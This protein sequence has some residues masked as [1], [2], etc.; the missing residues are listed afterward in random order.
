MRNITIIIVV[1]SNITL[2]LAQDGLILFDYFKL[3]CDGS[4]YVENDDIFNDFT[5]VGAWTKSSSSK[6]K[7][8]G[9][10]MINMDGKR[11][12]YADYIGSEKGNAMQISYLNQA[13]SIT[14]NIKRG[15]SL[16]FT[17]KPLSYSN[18]VYSAFLLDLSNHPNT[19]EE[20]EIFDYHKSGGISRGRV[21]MKFSSA[22]ES[23]NV[24]FGIKYNNESISNWST[25][26]SVSSPTLLVVKFTKN[27]L[28][29]S[30]ELF[31]NPTPNHAEENQTENFKVSGGKEDLRFVS[32]YMENK[33]IMKIGSIRIAK[34]F[35][36]AVSSISLGAVH[37]TENSMIV[38]AYNNSLYF[39]R[40]FEG[41]VSIYSLGGTI[42]QES[43]L[44]H[45]KSVRCFLG[46][47]IFLVRTISSNN[48]INTYKIYFD[49]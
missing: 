45:E 47:G 20:R 49:N 44:E 1:L 28:N 42:L 46:S 6:G 13:N 39:E 2:M 3:K 12:F 38:R 26:V 21:F 29:D 7:T 34:T 48:V 32:F 5:S 37:P 30:F 8:S 18:A 41:I 10:V 24:V 33:R 35:I 23:R 9:P 14:T 22:E 43:K 36:D 19:T 31:V 17:D 11:L 40:P 4:E 25:P 27:L 16:C 15:S